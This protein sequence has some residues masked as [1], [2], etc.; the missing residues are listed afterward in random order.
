MT[1]LYDKAIK[2]RYQKNKY[3]QDSLTNKR[4]YHKSILFCFSI[5]RRTSIAGDIH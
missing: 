2:Q 5:K 3:G 1:A 4:V